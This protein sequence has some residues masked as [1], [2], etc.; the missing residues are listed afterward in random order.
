MDSS[1]FSNF[2][3]ILRN[4][5]TKDDTSTKKPLKPKS[6]IFNKSKSL[7]FPNQTQ[8]HFSEVFNSP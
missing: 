6:F 3:S 8:K 7:K 5:T 1:S 4:N 2:N